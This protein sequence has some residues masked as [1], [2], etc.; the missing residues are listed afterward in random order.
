VSRVLVAGIG[1]VFDGDDGF[2]V[3]VVS[4]LARR[5]QPADVVVED[6]GIRGFDLACALLE[7]HGAAVLV[8]AVRRGHP[9]GTLE[10]IEP[11]VDHPELTALGPVD[12]HGLDPVAVLHLV[13]QIGGRP[14]RLLLVGCEPAT[15]EPQGEGMVGLSPPVDAAV[16]EAVPMVESLAARLAGGREV[17]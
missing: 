14:P 11:D 15:F 17:T 7:N 1:S 8:D 4:R 12:G 10:L 13:R 6:Y 2:G 3:E 16:D 5:P 9:P